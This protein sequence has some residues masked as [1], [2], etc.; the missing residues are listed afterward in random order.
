MSKELMIGALRQ[1][2][3]GDQILEILDILVGEYQED[4]EETIEE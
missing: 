2:K 4:S 3:T 1:G